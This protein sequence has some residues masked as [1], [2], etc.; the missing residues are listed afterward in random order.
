MPLRAGLF[1]DPEPGD[2]GMDHFFGF[3]VGTGLVV[4]RFILDVAYML[5]TGVVDSEATDTTVF[6]HN[7]LTSIVY[8]F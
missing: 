5:R 7:F 4:G 8:H 6:L 2:G 3:S 1:Y